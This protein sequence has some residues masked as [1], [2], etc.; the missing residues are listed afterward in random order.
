VFLDIE[1]GSEDEVLRNL[2]N[3]DGVTEVFVVYGVYDIVAKITADTLDKLKKII[4]SR[5]RQLSKV[6][7][8]NTL[9]IIDKTS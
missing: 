7:S 3:V 8:T 4:V 2:K 6:L 9:M 5:V 1:P